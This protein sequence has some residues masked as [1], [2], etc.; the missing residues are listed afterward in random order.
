MQKNNQKFKIFFFLLPSIILMLLFVFYPMIKTIII[1]FI[2]PSGKFNLSN[3]TYTYGLESFSIAMTNTIIY[4]IVVTSSELLLAFVISYALSQKIKFKNTFQTIFFLPYVTSVVAIGA[5]FQVMY[6]SEYGII[7]QLLNNIGITPI[8]W[9]GAE[10]ALLATIILGIWK[11]LAFNI[12]I[13][14]TAFSTIDPNLEKAAILD[15]FSNINIFLKIKFP[16]IKGVVAYLLTMNIIFN[17]KVYEEVVSLF[18]PLV[19]GPGGSDNT[20]V[21]MIS[22]MT[23]EDPA[24]AAVLA[25]TLLIIV[26]LIRILMILSTKIFKYLGNKEERIVGEKNE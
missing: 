4:T 9:L 18:G 13:L 7:N 14:F 23:L 10:H 25:V 22:K 20:V 15:N 26:I 19:A 2:T 5:V 12:L 17:I 6:N 11:G 16:Q 1:S 8:A 3:Y 21:Y 24:V